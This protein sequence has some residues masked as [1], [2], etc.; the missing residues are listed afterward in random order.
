MCLLLQLL[1]GRDA[2]LAGQLVDV[3]WLT[4]T[5]A[6][7]EDNDWR[8]PLAKRDHGPVKQ[9]SEELDHSWLGH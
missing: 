7:L 5:N 9:V 3:L 4:S 1:L 2:R 6:Q 8:L